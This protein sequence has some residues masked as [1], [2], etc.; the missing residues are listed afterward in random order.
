MVLPGCPGSV[1]AW[2]MIPFFPKVSE[3]PTLNGVLGACSDHGF[4][5]DWYV[6]ILWEFLAFFLFSNVKDE[7]H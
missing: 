2:D 3:G 7:W 6:T 1:D 4:F 5:G